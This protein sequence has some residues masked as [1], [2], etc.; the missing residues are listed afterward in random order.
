[1]LYCRCSLGS[2][3]LFVTPFGNCVANKI[4]KDNDKITPMN[5][6]ALIKEALEILALSLASAGVL[7]LFCLGIL[8][9]IR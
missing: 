9:L 5:N 1:M 3:G 8:E 2:L 6:K 7:T 4:K